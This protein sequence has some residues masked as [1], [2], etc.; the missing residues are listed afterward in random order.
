M[1]AAE[2]GGMRHHRRRQL[3][4]RALA[5]EGDRS[6]PTASQEVSL[7][8]G[9]RCQIR[10]AGSLVDPPDEVME[11]RLLR[12]GG[13]PG[14]Q[15]APGVVVQAFLEKVPDR[16]ILVDHSPSR[17]ERGL[18]GFLV[19][20]TDDNPSVF[21]GQNGPASATGHWT[22]NLPAHPE[23]DGAPGAGARSVTCPSTPSGP[24][25]HS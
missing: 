15:L 11:R 7:G 6:G 18:A 24:R 8:E 20:E 2:Q 13:D 19:A 12:V 21:R 5:H 1:L 16:Y 22:A 14:D 3:P 4:R 10:A 23:S 9:L 25:R 17:L